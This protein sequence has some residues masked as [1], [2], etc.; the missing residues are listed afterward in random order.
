MRL[1]LV[2]GLLLLPAVP[3]A[4]AAHTCTR[5]FDPAGSNVYLPIGGETCAGATVGL[6]FEFRCARP[7]GAVEADPVPLVF[8]TAGLGPAPVSTPV[9]V[10]A[11]RSFGCQ[12]GAIVDLEWVLAQ[13]P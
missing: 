12:T 13:L 10:A 2:L 8:A 3:L 9:F 7:V 4:S 11:A 5:G 1:A 6:G